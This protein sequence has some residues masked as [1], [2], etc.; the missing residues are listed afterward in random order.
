MTLDEL[1]AARQFAPEIVVEGRNM[2]TVAT[3]GHDDLIPLVELAMA[4]QVKVAIE[5]GTLYGNT[6]ANLCRAG[7]SG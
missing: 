4:T 6:V 1:I 7:T 5:F 2:P 3:H